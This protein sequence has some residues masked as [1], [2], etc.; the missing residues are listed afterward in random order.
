MLTDLYPW[1]PFESVWKTV[2]GPSPPMSA[3]DM[4]ARWGKKRVCFRRA[5]LGIFGP[6]SPITI[7]N[8]ENPCL[9][10]PLIRAYSDFIVR[11]FGLQAPSP[12]PQRAP[13]P[14]RAGRAARGPSR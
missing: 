8:K 6:A 13:R 1:G 10:S 11:G 5:V 9:R 4:R 12:R 14:R 7:I 3:W 2:F